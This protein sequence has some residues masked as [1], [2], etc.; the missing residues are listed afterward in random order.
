M[1]DNP[2]YDFSDYPPDHQC[3]NSTNKKVIGKF[4]DEAVE[5]GIFR[6]ITE[7][8]GLRPKMYSVK[9][10]EKIKDSNE[11]NKAKGVTTVTT[12]K[13]LNFDVYKSTLFGKEDLTHTNIS[14]RHTNHELN[15]IEVNK[16]SLS[17]LDTKR[18]ILDDGIT[19]YSYGHY[20]IKY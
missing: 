1:K 17:P 12:K 5:E 7:F 20:N 6:M 19:S 9:F 3:Y 13:H 14:I 16:V 11:K 18:Y 15:L 10:T 2:V 8:V 4:K